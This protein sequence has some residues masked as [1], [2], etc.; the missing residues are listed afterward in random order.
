[1]EK[2]PEV[3]RRPR[4]MALHDGPHLDLVP[5]ITVLSL[6]PGILYERSVA[7]E[8]KAGTEAVPCQPSSIKENWMA[9]VRPASITRL[10]YQ[11]TSRAFDKKKSPT[12]VRYSLG[13]SARESGV[14]CGRLCIH[15]RGFKQWSEVARGCTAAPAPPLPL[16]S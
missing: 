16:T 1:M 8:D 10:R 7:C 12:I 2:R 4:S 9:A 6:A 13:F 14:A 11:L 5:P 3:A 15:A